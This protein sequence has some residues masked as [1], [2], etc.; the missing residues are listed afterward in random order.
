MHHL[1]E[2]I[3]D[4]SFRISASPEQIGRLRYPGTLKYIHIDTLSC[5]SSLIGLFLYLIFKTW[6]I[7]N[8]LTEAHN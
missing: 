8:N 5:W 4:L 3:N 2:Q 1:I 7:T 6:S